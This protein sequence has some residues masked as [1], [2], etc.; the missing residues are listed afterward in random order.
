MPFVNV[1][2]SQANSN[3][4]NCTFD[5][6]DD[7]NTEDDFF[8][9]TNPSRSRGPSSTCA[10]EYNFSDQGATEGPFDPNV[11]G[12]ASDGPGLEG[13]V[14]PGT[15]VEPRV[16]LARFRGQ[17][18]QI[19]F[20]ATGVKMG[21]TVL[22]DQIGGGSYGPRDDGWFLD[23]VTVTRTLTEAATLLVDS[24][25]NSGLPGIEDTDS[26]GV[27]CDNC[28]EVS[29]PDQADQDGDLIGDACDDCPGDPR[30]DSDD[31]GICCPA[32]ICCQAWDPDQ[33]DTD[34]D[35]RGDA[36]DN[37]PGVANP[38]QTDDVHPGGD[39]D[40]CDDPDADG[41]ADREDNCPDTPNVDQLN[42]D[43]DGLG[44][45]CDN[46]PFTESTG[47]DYD[48]DGVGD[49]CDSCPLTGDHGVDVDGDGVDAVC[50]NC[51]DVA[52]PDQS[53]ADG[54][55]LG[56]A[57]DNCPLLG[58][59]D[60]ADGDGDGV[61]SACDRCPSGDGVDVDL[62]GLPCVDDPCPDGPQAG[63]DGDEDGLD[64]ACDPCPADPD[65]D[66]D[67]D[68]LCAI[69]D[70]CPTIANPEQSRCVK[71]PGE[72][73]ASYLIVPSPDGAWVVYNTTGNDVYS[74]STVG[75]PPVRLH[76][77]FTDHP[78]EAF[79]VLPDSS[80]VVSLD[81]VRESGVQELFV[82]PIA[83]GALLRL[84]HALPI[85]VDVARHE[86]DPAGTRVF[87][88]VRTDGSGPYDLHA[89]DR[90]GAN[91]TLLASG[92]D[93]LF[94]VGPIGE[95]VVYRRAQRELF[96][97]PTAGG[98][99]VPLANVDPANGTL[100]SFEFEPQET[101]VVFLV[102]GDSR[103]LHKVGIDGSAPVVL[104]TTRY[105]DIKITPDGT[106]VIYASDQEWPGTIELYE[107]PLRGGEPIRLS[108][109]LP[110]E[111][112]IVSLGD[113]S[114][115]S[116]W[117]LFLAEDDA[118]RRVLY[119]APLGSGGAFPLSLPTVSGGW[120]NSDVGLSANRVVYRTEEAAPNRYD[121]F[122]VRYDGQDRIRLNVPGPDVDTFRMSPDGETVVWSGDAQVHA[123][124]VAGGYDVRL[125]PGF[126]SNVSLL[127]FAGPAQL[128]FMSDD[129]LW[130]AALEPDPDG[131]GFIVPCD[132]CPD[133]RTTDQAD[134]DHDAV[135]DACDCAADDAT[136]WAVPGEVG[137][138][139][140][141]HTGG[142][143]GVTTLTWTAPD[144]SG[145]AEVA[146][147]VL[148]SAIPDD[149]IFTVECLARSDPE[150]T[151]AEDAVPPAPGGTHYFLAFASNPC[152]NGPVGHSRIALR[153]CPGSR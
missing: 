119:S 103:T 133:V 11:I 146:F 92:F 136:A 19:R 76:T 140:L 39:G 44:S 18:L 84:S 15:W 129:R 88:S 51:A 83:G 152:G 63:F 143:T 111:Q 65:N 14:G 55:G 117:V 121:L 24:S 80:A 53:D 96:A 43:A 89:V 90:D 113:V 109:G 122:S 37:C 77:A 149:F 81:D 72:E 62:D 93:G 73:R 60:Q 33:A 5:P 4:F 7:G 10:P 20:L 99:S 105:L 28:P 3:Y 9:P 74:V 78:S 52:N 100:H 45:A 75:G 31:D 153:A 54:D 64:D 95:H 145:G 25:D 116:R 46:C 57:C 94:Q 123:V 128:L 127:D 82:A 30:N 98:A 35:G 115:D 148:R 36:C 29:N 68:G 41:V 150:S 17:S 1:Y 134:G 61:G 22:W 8:D 131:D 135:G 85:D 79:S 142:T 125:N 97:V 87:Y 40:A 120:V 139:S 69:A 34:D 6:T 71:L 124:P 118:N 137:N 27:F 48:G 126:T 47:A 21:S 67:A 132:N 26:D 102:R 38:D 141:S 130:L 107:V 147:D 108:D 66:R 12:E 56:D 50:D 23:D 16:D 110:A 112:R 106:R 144:D 104:G 138:L 70:N 86:V 2:D 13:S 91:H 114:P 151:T 32:D 58:N 42:P 59:P 101:A 49:A